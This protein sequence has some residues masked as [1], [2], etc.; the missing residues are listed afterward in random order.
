MALD[1]YP[2][3]KPAAAFHVSC[4]GRKKMMGTQAVRES[5]ISKAYLKDIPSAGYYAYGEFSPLEKGS[6]AMFHGTT[7][8]TLLIGEE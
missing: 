7:F 6:A 1:T 3:K 4:A 8:V 2:G 5:Q